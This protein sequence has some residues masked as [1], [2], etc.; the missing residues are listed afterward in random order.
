MKL[1]NRDTDYA[2][3]A[4]RYISRHDNEVVS[5]SKIAK[6]LK[7]PRPFLRKILQI[8]Q[9]NGL[10]KSFE[11]RCGGF[12]MAHPAENILLVDLIK[13]FQGPLELSDCIL[14]KRICPDIERCLLKHKIKHLEQLVIS[15]LKNITI[16]A[17]SRQKIP[18]SLFE[19]NF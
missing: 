15:E 8:L 1:I 2:M 3:R 10:L 11:G 18:C 12:S 6:A 19:I 4:L 16:A 14:K 9:K 7:I 5:V 13:I 17:L